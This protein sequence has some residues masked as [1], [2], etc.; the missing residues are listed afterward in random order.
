MKKKIIFTVF[1]FLLLTDFLF[2]QHK[3]KIGLSGSIQSDQFGILIPIW[4][5]E[6]VVLA[7]A[8]D[9]KFAE[10]VGTDFSIGLVPRFYFKNEKLCPYFGLK[11]GT[12]INIPSTDNKVESETTYDI[13]GGLAV[14]AEYFI[15]DYFSLG[16]E[17]QGNFT[18]SSKESNRF[19]NPGGLNFNTATMISATIYF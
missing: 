18:K 13:I 17:A 11:V 6:K 7:P 14:G 9:F 4:L 19:G 10:K 15:V 12:A 16:V 2:A 1:T 8:F 3:G 5:G